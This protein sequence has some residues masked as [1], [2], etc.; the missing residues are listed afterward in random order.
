MDDFAFTQ[1]EE[2][3]KVKKT[4]RKV[5]ESENTYKNLRKEKEEFQEK[6]YERDQT[7]KSNNFE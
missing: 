5:Q 3:W 2:S 7:D 6:A 1:L 4:L